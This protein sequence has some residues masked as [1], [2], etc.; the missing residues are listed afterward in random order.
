[1]FLYIRGLR[2][3]NLG[4]KSMTIK[5]VTS[6]MKTALGYFGSGGGG[7]TLPN[8]LP[9]LFRKKDDG[10]LSPAEQKPRTPQERTNSAVKKA[11][12][13][14]DYRYNAELN[15][16]AVNFT[17]EIE[18]APYSMLLNSYAAYKNPELKDIKYFSK[19]TV[20]ATYRGQ[21]VRIKSSDADG[22]KVQEI[23]FEDGSQV[24]YTTFLNDGKMSLNGEDFDIPSGT[25]VETK[26]VN[27]RMFSQ[28]IQLPDMKRKVVEIPEYIKEA[29]QILRVES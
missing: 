14:N 13:D 11:N 15:R 16:S 10:G 24:C 2:A 9:P 7:Y 3:S 18:D 25:V 17:A 12:A 8:L 1:M 26:S 20:C 4:D 27:G 29:G 22:K 6:T 5:E 23:N 19:N 21:S 28:L